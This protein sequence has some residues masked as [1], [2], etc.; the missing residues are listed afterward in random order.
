[1]QSEWCIPCDVDESLLVEVFYSLK[2]AYCARLVNTYIDGECCFQAFLASSVHCYYRILMVCR[3]YTLVLECALCTRSDVCKCGD[4]CA[5]AEEFQLHIVRKRSTSD[6]CGW[7]LHADVGV[8]STLITW[9]N[10]EVSWYLW[11]CCRHL[12]NLHVVYEERALVCLAHAVNTEVVQTVLLGAICASKGVAT[13]I[14]CDVGRCDNLL[15]ECL[16]CRS[17]AYGCSYALYWIG[18]DG[19]ERELVSCVLLHVHSRRY[20]PVVTRVFCVVLISGCFIVAIESPSRFVVVCV[21]NCQLVEEFFAVYRVLVR[22]L[23][24][25]T[26]GYVS[27]LCKLALHVAVVGCHLIIIGGEVGRSNLVS[28][29]IL[30]QTLCKSRYIRCVVAVHTHYGVGQFVGIEEAAVDT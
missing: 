30:G 23:H 13:R 25:Y 27:R 16:C 12:R 9:H 8:R 4:V 10:L 14:V 6:G 21:D 2:V 22:Q 3:L 1:M 15:G 7:C 17:Q 20:E 5:V 18:V 24:A 29:C 11:C 19:I 26:D 28:V